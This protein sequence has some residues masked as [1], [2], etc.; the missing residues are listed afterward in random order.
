MRDKIKKHQLGWT[1][2]SAGTGNYHTGEPPHELSQKV[3]KINGIDI[4]MQRAKQ[5]TKNDMQ[6]YDLIYVMD[7]SNYQEVKRISG[8]FWDA[9]KTDFLLNEL[10]ANE[11]RNVPDPWF[12][13]EDGYHTVFEMIDKACEQIIVKYAGKK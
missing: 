4:T 9:S 2:T 1:V 6:H 12:G 10:Y 13:A 11:N 7:S 3:A 8:N 5:F